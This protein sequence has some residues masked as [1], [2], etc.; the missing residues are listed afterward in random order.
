MIYQILFPIAA[1]LFCYVLLYLAQLAYRELAS[2]LRHVGGPKSPSFLFGNFK[3]MT[4][5]SD[6]HVTEKWRSEF[7]PNFRFRGL[8]S[9]SEFHTSDVKALNHIMTNS[10]IYQRAPF[11]IENSRLLLGHGILTVVQD[12]HK[13]QA[14]LAQ[15]LTIICLIGNPAF[16]VA[17]IKLITEVFVEKVVRLRDIWAAQ[18]ARNPSATRVEVL[19]WLRRMTLDVIG[20]AGFDYDFDS[21]N[22]TGDSN[23]L[24]EAFTELLHSP[25]AA[26][27]TM[28]RL[29]QSIMPALQLLPL[30]GMKALATARQGMLSIGGKIVSTS[31]AA[32]KASGGEGALN[33]RRDLLSVLLKANMSTNI[34]ES[35]RLTDDEVIAQIPAFFIAG[36]ETTRFS[37]FSSTAW[38]LHAL[39]LNIVAQTKLRAELLTVSTDNPTMDELNSLEY[40]EMVVRETMRLHAPV[41]FIQRMAMQDDVLPL[42][43]PYIDK[44]GNA[45]D[46]LPIPKGQVIHLPILALNTDM[47]I[48]GPDAG[49]FRPERWEKIPDGA[50]EIP[51]VWANLFTFFAGPHNCIG[52]RFSLVEL[53]ALLF[54]LVSAFEFE[55]AVPKGG[56]GPT[57]SFI[58]RPM[59]VGDTTVG[60]QLPLIVKPFNPQGF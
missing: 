7:G 32:T 34:P 31:K 35:Q 11:S 53:K 29:L 58:Q 60:S 36:H 16:G 41:V 33:G 52:F 28:F 37:P 17:Q 12:E 27:T 20:Q 9:M 3:Q 18:V 55:A 8:F 44:A 19:S 56:I 51:G 46:S 57:A 30:P 1:T 14:S 6:A 23:E 39:S 38:A 26:R 24:H 2:P 47:D 42:A 25:N 49:E 45:H 15:L 48:W 21:L 54:T 4:V 43:K 50:S 10:A 59:V 5:R 22:P 40:L 13:R